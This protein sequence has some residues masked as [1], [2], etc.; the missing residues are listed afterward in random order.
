MDAGEKLACIERLRQVV[1]C[2]GIETL[3]TVQQLGLRRQHEDRR[4]DMLLAQ[5]PRH[6]ISIHFRHH[7]IQDEEIIDPG[8]RII[9]PGFSIIYR[10]GLIPLLRQQ[11]PD[12]ICEEL[13]IFYD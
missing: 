9:D 6:L 10:L 7:D 5:N 2:P 1:V 13:F 3:Y 12:R 8:R 4:T 11:I